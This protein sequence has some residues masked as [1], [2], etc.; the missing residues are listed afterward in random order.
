MLSTRVVLL[1]NNISIAKVGEVVTGD[2]VTGDVV[3]GEVVPNIGLSAV[4][5]IVM[6]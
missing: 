4:E 5:S 1:R 6:D 3:T 2:V